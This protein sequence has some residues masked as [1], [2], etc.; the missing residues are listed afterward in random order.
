M[1]MKLPTVRKT[2]LSVVVLL[3]SFA[4]VPPT[5]VFAQEG[6]TGATGGTGFVG[7]TG[8]TGGTGATGEVGS[9]GPTGL[10]GETGTTGATGSIGDTGPTGVAGPTGKTGATGSTG[11]TGLTGPTGTTGTTGGTGITGPTGRTGSTGGTGITGPTGATGTTGVSGKSGPTGATGT[12]GSIGATGPTG[13]KGQAG[14]VGPDGEPLILDGGDFLYPNASYAAHLRLDNIYLG[15]TNA[16]GTISTVGT[17]QNLLID[18]NGT[19]IIDLEGN[20]GVGTAT[21]ASLLTVGS[22]GYFQIMKTSAGAPAAADCDSDSERGRFILNT[23]NNRLHI[24]N[25][26][27]RGWDYVAL[28]N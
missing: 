26:A 11:S 24:C 3:I 25:G 19:G 8:P 18:P 10:A 7:E 22:S 16:T 28:T 23:T 14:A 9:A 6:P 20:V 15:L 27:T 4:F 13:D 17:N 1:G 21:P 5:F 2:L 12:T